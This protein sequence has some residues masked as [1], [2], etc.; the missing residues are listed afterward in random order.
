GE[1]GEAARLDRGVAHERVEGL[2]IRLGGGTSLGPRAAEPV[3]PVVGLARRP[4]GP[5]VDR[6]LSVRRGIRGPHGAAG[7]PGG[8]QPFAGLHGKDDAGLRAAGR[9]GLRGQGRPRDSQADQE[10]ERERTAHRNHTP[11]KDS[12]SGTGGSFS[13]PDHSAP[14]PRSRLARPVRRYRWVTWAG[15]RWPS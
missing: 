9:P 7:G 14:R 12:R 15:W 8:H 11:S 2:W 1:A 5:E 13:S 4:E 3:L 6:P 10:R